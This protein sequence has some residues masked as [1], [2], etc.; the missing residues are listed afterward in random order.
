MR[1]ASHSNNHLALNWCRLLK[2]AW[3]TNHEDRNARHLARPRSSIDERRPRKQ[4]NH[5]LR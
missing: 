3:M 5:T 2:D 4:L 1:L